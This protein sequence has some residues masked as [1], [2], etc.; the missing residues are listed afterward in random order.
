M[1]MGGQGVYAP[2]FK[3]ERNPQCLVSGSGIVLEVSREATLTLMMDQMGE[4]PR[5]RLKAPSIRVEG[6]KL[7][8]T[9]YMRGI[10]E[11]DYKA[12]LDMPISSFFDDGAELAVTDPGVPTPIKLIV[13][14]TDVQID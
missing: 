2:T 4:D 10:L 1:Y 14:F 12:H 9:I 13:Q 6:G 3:Y 11:E 7:G 8:D 5:L